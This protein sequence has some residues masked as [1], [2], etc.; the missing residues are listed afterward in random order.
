MQL[1]VLIYSS[2]WEVDTSFLRKYLNS[3]K[4]QNAN[5]RVNFFK[6]C[7]VAGLKWFNLDVRHAQKLRRV[8]DTE[9]KEYTY[10]F[11]SQSSASVFIRLLNPHDPLE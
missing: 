4:S 6:E 3:K 8:R 9:L 10:S 11:N 1:N 7:S 2:N 5:Q